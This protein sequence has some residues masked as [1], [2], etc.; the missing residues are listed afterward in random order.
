MIPARYSL[1][2][3]MPSHR[4]MD[5]VSTGGLRLNMEIFGPRKSR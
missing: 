1:Q 3:M 4:R 2:A 5:Q